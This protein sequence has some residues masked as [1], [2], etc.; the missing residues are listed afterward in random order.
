VAVMTAVS[1]AQDPAGWRGMLPRSASAAAAANSHVRPP[2]PVSGPIGQRRAGA[3]HRGPCITF[4]RW[5]KQLHAPK[6]NHAQGGSSL[7]A[8]APSWV[9][10]RD[11]G[12][13]TGIADAARDCCRRPSQE[14]ALQ[15][16][17]LSP[18]ACEQ[19]LFFTAFR[20]ERDNRCSLQ[21]FGGLFDGPF[22]GGSTSLT[23][24]QSGDIHGRRGRRANSSGGSKANWM[25]A[26]GPT[27]SMRRA[28]LFAIA[29]SIELCRFGAG[30]T[31]VP[32]CCAASPSITAKS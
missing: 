22:E 6:H 4:L 26:R 31:H 12:Q 14:D 28:N 8:N 13:Q 2:A 3:A 1:F 21:S 18:A 5:R 25:R 23:G 24:Q 32:M 27:L 11:T 19:S 7:M 15:R 17:P 10:P 30:N 16:P 9:L 20:G 29:H